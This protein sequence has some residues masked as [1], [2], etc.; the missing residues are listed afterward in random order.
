MLKGPSATP[1]GE[2]ERKGEGVEWGEN[3]A[4]YSIKYKYGLCL[5]YN[6]RRRNQKPNCYMH[7][8]LGSMTNTCQK[9]EN[10]QGRHVG[11]RAVEVS[12]GFG[13]MLSA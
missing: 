2:G 13:L 10:T 4:E 9:E 12:S 3:K 5:H 6:A 8:G 1:K 11:R 7:N